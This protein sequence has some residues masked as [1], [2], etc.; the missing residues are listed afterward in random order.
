MVLI[1]RD[2]KFVMHKENS[3]YYVFQLYVFPV[4]IAF[5]LQKLQEK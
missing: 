2:N 3:K 1:F 5:H 4:T